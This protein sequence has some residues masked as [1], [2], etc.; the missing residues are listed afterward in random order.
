MTPQDRLIGRAHLCWCDIS[1]SIE[2]HGAHRAI[3]AVAAG[4]DDAIAPQ[5][6][7]SDWHVAAFTK[8]PQLAPCGEIVSADVFPPI[9]N[10]L[11]AVR[12]CGDDR[13][14]PCRDFLAPR[15]PDFAS[16]ARVEDGEKLFAQH[17]ALND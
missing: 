12:R 5:N 17:V 13:R 10:H 8:P 4:E 1:G 3:L 11:S 16:V 2:T 9:H 14:A 7:R 15:A 6:R